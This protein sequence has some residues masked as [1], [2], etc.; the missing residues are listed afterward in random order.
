MK[1]LVNFGYAGRSTDPWESA[2][3]P[4]EDYEGGMTHAAMTAPANTQSATLFHGRTALFCRARRR[5]ALM[6][7]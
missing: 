7:L 6:T 4:G 2:V 3:A 5:S 1:G